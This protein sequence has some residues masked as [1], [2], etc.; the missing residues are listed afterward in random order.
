LLGGLL[1][2]GWGTWAVMARVPVYEVASAARIEVAGGIHVIQSPVEGRVIATHLEL[3]KRV[4]EGAV[5]VELDATELDKTLEERVAERG[6]YRAE[7]E[8]LEREAE[9]ERAALGVAKSAESAAVAEARAREAEAH[10]EA[11]SAERRVAVLKGLQGDVVS[12][13]DVEQARA[14]ATGRRR[15]IKTLQRGADRLRWDHE[16]KLRDRL[17]VLARLERGAGRMRAELA[18]L[19]PVIERLEH[20]VALRTIRAPRAGI[21]GRVTELRAGGVVELGTELGT[22][23]PENGDLRVIAHYEPAAALGR[24]APGQ[25]A[26]LRLDGFPW[27]EYGSVPASV[28]GIGSEAPGGLVRVELSVDAARAGAIPLQHG[29]TTAV[30][31]EVER[32]SPALLL[33]RAAGKLVEP[34]GGRSGA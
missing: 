21:I 9:A 24:V 27:A 22:V 12:E 34:A 33:L 2:V 30:E 31:V 19:E 7:L 11:E 5:L 20:E 28:T 6:L 1:I 16:S 18:R 25:T 23:V 15:G 10:P 8:G 32:V 13:L 3:G 17:V 4:E 26:N 14:E 29:L